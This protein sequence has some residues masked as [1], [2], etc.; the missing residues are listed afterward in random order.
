MPLPDADGRV[1][2][3]GRLPRRVRLQTRFLLYFTSLV[4]AVMAFTILL[5]EQHL[6]RIIA[7]EAEVRAL[8]L[9]RSLAAVSQPALARDDHAVLAQNAMH[10][11]REDDGITEIV[12][13]DREGRVAADSDHPGRRGSLPADPAVLG[14]ALTKRDLVMATQLSRRDGMPGLEPGLDVAVPVLSESGK[15]RLGTVRLVFTTEEMR[16]QIGDMRLDLAGVGAA[17]VALGILGSFVLARRITRPLSELVAGAVRA[18]D[19]DLDTPLHVRSGDEIEDLAERFDVMVRRIRD[20]H[21]RLERRSRDLQRLSEAGLGLAEALHSEGVLG[22]V[23][24][25]AGIFVGAPHAQA[26]AQI[27]SRDRPWW[28][29][30]AAAPFTIEVRKAL[31]VELGRRR[32][33]GSVGLPSALP[34]GTRA[35]SVAHGGTLLGWIFLEGGPQPSPEAEGLLA[36]LAGQAAA[37]LRN[38]QLLEERLESERL[39]TIGRMISTIVHDFRNPMTAIRGYAAMI[40][41]M[42][43]GPDRRRQCAHLVVEETDRLNG[44]IDEILEFTRGGPTRLRRQSVS[45]EELVAKLQRVLEPDLQSRG[46]RFAQDL[47]YAGAVTVD[48]DRMLRAMINIASNALDA[49]ESG[50]TFLV[51]S[52]ER[53]AHVEIDLADDG[54]GIPEELQAR[55]YEPFFTH[56][57]PRGIGLGMSITRKVVEEHG[58]QIRIDSEVGRGTTF[59]VSLP[60][61]VAARPAS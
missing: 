19:G 17:A 18:A 20:E 31:E 59:T 53:N 50:G 15:E 48:V 10:A 45:L 8:S 29:S 2:G 34:A 9:A 37:T 60:A 43:L 42:D 3:S 52:R 1:P 36:I 27:G 13:F 61:D 56:G 23:A 54:R 35:V 47:A 22:L 55:I 38:I 44:M 46:I 51:R 41:E 30:P 58:G 14:L 21:H 24:E 39:S 12:I 16:A 11:A 4:V 5:V 40:E 26:V 57:K 28:S 32:S 25:A 7:R 49:M 6:G 33:E